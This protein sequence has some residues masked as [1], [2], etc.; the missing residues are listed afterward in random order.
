MSAQPPRFS[1]VIP[2]FNQGAFLAEALDSLRAQTLPPHEIIVVDD[3]STDPYSVQRMDELCVGGVKL[4]RQENR[5][6]SGARNS[7]IRAATGDWILPLDADDRLAPDALE[8]CATAIAASPEVDVWY[9]DIQ[10]F[11]L[12]N[13]VWKCFHFNPW[14]QLWENQMVC[15]SA[16]RRTVFDAGVLYNER[17]RQGYEDWEFYIHACVERGFQARSLGKPIFHYRRWGYSMLSAADAKRAMLVEQLRRERP[18]FQD[19]ARLLELKRRHNPFLG[20]AAESPELGAA[21]A[22][23]RF[24]DFRVVEDTGRVTRQGDLA[25]FGDVPCS[26]VLVSVADAPLAAALRADPFLLEKVARTLQQHNPP[27]LWLVTTEPDSAW[28]GFLP[29]EQETRAASTRCVGF[30]LAPSA[31]LD[32]PDISRL[33]ESLVEDLAHHLEHRG[34]RP[35]MTLVVG[36][37]LS[38][39]EGVALPVARAPQAPPPMAPPAPVLAERTQLLRLGAKLIGKGVNHL[40]QGTLNPSMHD[41]LMRSGVVRGLRSRLSSP[42]PALPAQERGPVRAGPLSLA[43]QTDT[44]SRD[45]RNYV[46]EQPPR[47]GAPLTGDSPAVLVVTPSLAPGPTSRALVQLV[48]EMA[49]AAPHQ[50][51]YLLL[52]QEEPRAG[53][54]LAHASELLPHLTGAFCLPGLASR[55]PAEELPRLVERL[56]VEGVLISDSRVAFDALPALRKLPRRVRIVAHAHELRRAPVPDNASACAYAAIRFNNL[57]DAYYV[58]SQ[59]VAKQ[60]VRDLYVSASKVHVAPPLVDA[61]RTPPVRRPPPGEGRSPRVLWFHPA[62]ASDESHLMLLEL[63]RLWKRRHPGRAL[64]LQLIPQAPLAGWLPQALEQHRLS[65]VVRPVPPVEDLLPLYRDADCL[66]LPAFGPEQALAAWEAL[67]AGL[68]V[69]AAPAGRGMSPEL[70]SRL[71]MSLEQPE[72]PFDYLRGLEQLLDDPERL[73]AHIEMARAACA[74]PETRTQAVRQLEALLLPPTPPQPVRQ[75]AAS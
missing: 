62:S 44:R 26:R 1:V 69:M 67:A 61:G 68:P 17:M 63:V 35:P 66:I 43:V 56:G 57:L 8:T 48:Q 21:L 49:R 27:V 24:Q 39:S 22:G 74:A 72:Q 73:R 64:D 4:V 3:G 41:R 7:G 11:G 32:A 65:D 38:P 60:L 55:S 29:S 53:A 10:Y 37:H 13:F 51:R 15:S 31:F 54:R 75:R 36:P 46:L 5:G 70:A 23:Q 25:V 42:P 47:F 18:I 52:T 12:E 9:P 28:P 50:R 40:A 19:E 14:R 20:V 30:C 2:C 71:F 6:L 34:A 16:I 45:T 58:S 59:E 33:G